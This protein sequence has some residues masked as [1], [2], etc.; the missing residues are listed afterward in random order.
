MR[1]SQ[2]STTSPR[3]M[4]SPPQWLAP[5][6]APPVSQGQGPMEARGDGPGAPA[7]VQRGAVGSDH[8]GHDAP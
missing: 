1:H 5:V 8:G 2:E 3:S 4:R 6:S 7:H